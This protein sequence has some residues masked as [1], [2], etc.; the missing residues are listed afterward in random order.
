VTARDARGVESAPSNTIEIDGVHVAN[1]LMVNQPLVCQTGCS[2]AGMITSF[3]PYSQFLPG[4]L[5]TV[6]VG[7]FNHTS[8]EL[9]ITYNPSDRLIDSGGHTATANAQSPGH[10]G[11]LPFITIPPNGEWDDAILF[12]GLQPAPGT[13]CMFTAN[14]TQQ[15]S[16]SI[17]YQSLAVPCG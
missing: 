8:K 12:M 5:V 9:E 3:V 1:D 4:G 15:G 2:A 17:T 7:Y 11:P 6:E 10:Q 13:Q 14:V 16:F